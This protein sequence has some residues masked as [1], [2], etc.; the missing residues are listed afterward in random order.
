MLHEVMPKFIK[1]SGG[2]LVISRQES[3]IPKPLIP[4]QLE[5]LNFDEILDL[6]I[7]VNLSNSRTYHI[8]LQP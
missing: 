6:K 3:H 1:T 5:K 2:P 8:T 7:E 4:T